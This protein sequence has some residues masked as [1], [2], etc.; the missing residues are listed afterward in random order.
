[1]PRIF[2]LRKVIEQQAQP[3]LGRKGRQVFHQT[4]PNR[5]GPR[6]SARRAPG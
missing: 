3:R 4:L 1:L 6:E 2:D 5:L